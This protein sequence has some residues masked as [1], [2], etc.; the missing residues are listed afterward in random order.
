[1]RYEPDPAIHADMLLDGLFAE[2]LS[3]KPLPSWFLARRYERYAWENEIQA[4]DINLVLE[5]V[6]AGGVDRKRR[7][8]DLPDG[9]RDRTMVYLIPDKGAA[10]I[11]IPHQPNRKRA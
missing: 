2:G 9:T 3:G 4:I 6:H 11:A 10:V 5:A 7:V 1:M 8:A